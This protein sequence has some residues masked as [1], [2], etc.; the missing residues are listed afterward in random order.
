MKKTAPKA[1][2]VEKCRP[3]EDWEDRI[4]RAMHPDY[5]RICSALPHR[6]YGGVRRRAAA[7]LLV[8]KKVRWSPALRLALR[9]GG[10]EKFTDQEVAQFMG[11]TV[12]AAK[13]ARQSMGIFRPTV[14]AAE[15]RSPLVLD[16]R[17]RAKEMSIP[18]TD[19][20]ERVGGSKGA[21]H[22]SNAY[23]STAKMVR[24]LGGELYVE[25]ED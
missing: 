21:L 10:F 19:L 17:Q 1:A 5:A 6:T 16:I 20:L 15:P 11:C 7:L 12:N 25:W 9:E 18:L 24:V 3:Y 22:R 13:L 14:A 4:I 8:K 23:S 2:S